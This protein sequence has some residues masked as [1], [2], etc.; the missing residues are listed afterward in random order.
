MKEKFI[1]IAIIVIFF[2]CTGCSNSPPNYII[3]TWVT[4]TTET[5][6]GP[7]I[8]EYTFQRDYKLLCSI[9][10]D[11]PDDEKEVSSPQIGQFKMNDKEIL[12]FIGK[13]ND[14]IR[15]KFKGSTLLIQSDDEPEP[16]IFRRKKD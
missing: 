14:V 8:I 2:S 10:S 4:E 12:I 9:R 7:L 3:G 13:P 6:W 11:D 1:F 5:E 15:G 16:M